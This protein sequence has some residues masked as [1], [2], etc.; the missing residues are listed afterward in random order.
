MLRSVIWTGWVFGYVG[1]ALGAYTKC[2]CASSGLQRRSG[3]HAGCAEPPP[4]FGVRVWPESGSAGSD[5]RK[6]SVW[7]RVAAADRPAAG[8]GTGTHTG[9]HAGKSAWTQLEKKKKKSCR[10]CLRCGA[11][12][13][14]I[15]SDNHF[16]ISGWGEVMPCPHCLLSP[17]ERRPLSRSASRSSIRRRGGAGEAAT[18]AAV[19]VEAA[20]DWRWNHTDRNMTASHMICCWQFVTAGA[21]LI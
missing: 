21:P 8:I 15:G 11:S 18:S 5:A 10:L 17:G 4:S 16:V 14:V 19:G 6:W 9:P 1:P 3:F 7:Q 13:L 12:A 2:V 20:A